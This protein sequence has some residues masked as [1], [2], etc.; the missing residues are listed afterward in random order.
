MHPRRWVRLWIGALLV[1][2]AAL[3]GLLAYQPSI[4]ISLPTAT[5]IRRQAL[6]PSGVI[7]DRNGRTLY[8]LIDPHAG[9]HRPL[10]LED[11]SRH[12][13]QA[14][15]ATEDASFYDNPGLNLRA[16][17]RALWI[18]LRSGKIVSGGSTI[19]QQLARN[20]L[21]TENE[22]RQKTW[23]RK[24]RETLLAYHMTRTLSKQEIL[25]L[26]LNEIYFGN[27][28]YGV[29]AAARSYFAKSAAEL[30]L[31][32]SALL[33]G[34]PQSPAN[35][36][37][38]TYLDAAKRRQKVVLDLMVKGGHISARE[39]ALAFRE[40]LHFAS[41]STAI[42][43][44]H[45][46]MLVRAELA[47]CLGEEVIRAGG[48]RVH[49][50]LDLDLQ[51]AA[52]AHVRRHLAELNRESAKEPG[53]NVRNAAVV[54]LDPRDGAVL[55][56]VGSPDYFDRDIDGAVNAV[57]SLRQPG[58]AIKPFTYAAAFE[59]GYSPST[60]VADVYTPFLTREDRPYVPINYDYRF[61]G[62]VSLREALASS[63]NVVAV[64]LLD[65]IGVKAL[66]SMARRLGITT[67]DQPDRHGLA[68]TLGSCE[69]QLLQLTTAY[70]ALATG[71]WSVHPRLIDHVEDA[72]GNVIYR[73]QPEPPERVLDE[74]V[75][76]LVT[77]ILSDDRA[78]IA[79]FGEE[80]MLNMPFLAAVKTG[81]TTDWRDNWTIGYTTEVVTGVW[82]GNA[83]NE[84][85]SRISGVTGAA[86]IWNAVMHSAH[87][88]QPRPFR[89]PEGL[90][91][92]EVCTE[93]GLLPGIA[94]MHRKRELFLAENAPTDRCPMHR[95]LTVDAATG[96][97]ARPDCPADRRVLRRVT[98][99]PPEALVW[100]EEEGLPLP[101]AGLTGE[102]PFASLQDEEGRSP[103]PQSGPA[104]E[105]HGVYL[106]SPA[107]NSRYVIAPS[108]PLRS[109][110]LEIVASCLP[111]L[112]LRE[113][114]LWVDQERWHTW[115]S[116]PYRV[117]WPL[118]PGAHEFRVEAFG[119]D[120]IPIISPPL[121]ITVSPAGGNERTSP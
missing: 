106:S 20:L 62:P 24:L 104:P 75:A 42:E 115:S 34:L 28:A 31:A 87:S 7:L 33:A 69:V 117:L 101:P 113:A 85:M 13:R 93:S 120:L 23:Q 45:A 118:S 6:A 90:V 21:L 110:S 114:T 119:R 2:G 95:L 14:I 55:A 46:C 11:I 92:V 10:E 76:Y 107:P 35:Y 43:A 67:L 116:P 73:P 30:D 98:F 50:T 22:R 79:S 84:P 38:L 60:V 91:E 54:V 88:Q 78:R 18:N 12:L 5:T 65:D 56:M 51:R 66:P 121:R 64:K 74:R 36:D 9:L 102:L 41:A 1:A 96:E 17:A 49:T 19:T 53:H 83:D 105:P 16:I 48:L 109:Q 59:Q 58:S 63:Y 52:L 39:A 3:L 94:C 100:A 86:P 103:S 61:H 25:A 8:E 4:L 72:E 32:E 70:A 37:P 108:I 26:Y 111:R 27:M 82:V 77:D 97:V 40:P 112:N 47:Q 57:L 44:P 80:S 71:G 15:I 29:G 81:T 68:L 99:W 89:R